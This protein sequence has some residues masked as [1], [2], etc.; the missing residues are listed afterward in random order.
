MASTKSSASMQAQLVSLLTRQLEAKD[1]EIARLHAIV[2]RLMDAQ[3]YRPSVDRQ[4]P[5][6][7]IVGTATAD[8]D[9]DVQEFDQEQDQADIN[10]AEELHAKY[11]DNMAK[12]GE[13]IQDIASERDTVTA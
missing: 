2:D 5:L 10:V 6:K 12:I 1:Q 13:A 4:E 3:F 8:V 11:R 9:P 7:H